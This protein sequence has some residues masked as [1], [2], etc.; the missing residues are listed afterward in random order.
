MESRIW[1]SMT[2]RE[3]QKQLREY[4]NTQKM[5]VELAIKLLSECNLDCMYEEET[6]VALDMAIKALEQEPKSP[7]DLCKYNPPGSGDGKPCTMCPAESED[8]E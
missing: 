7:C 4:S 1:D 8:K 5:P 6:S 3:F 2:E